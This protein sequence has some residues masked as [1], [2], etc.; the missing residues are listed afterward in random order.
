MELALPFGEKKLRFEAPW[1]PG[2]LAIGRR[3]ARPAPTPWDRLAHKA[4]DAPIGELPLEEIR[5]EDLQI[6]LLLE[7]DPHAPPAEEVLPVV[8]DR[9][10]QA[11]AEDDRIAIVGA[12]GLKPPAPEKMEEHLGGDIASRIRWSVHDPFSDRCAFRGFTALGTP[13]FVN[14]HVASAEFRLAVG[15]VEPHPTRGYSGGHDGILRACS[16]ETILHN[17]NLSFGPLSSYGHLGDNPCR[18]DADNVGRA[19]GLDYVLDFV[20]TPDGSPVGAFAGDPL[21]A[22]RAAA[23]Q[24]DRTVWGAEL[25]DLADAAIASPG[26]DR[27]T[28][29]PFEPRAIEFVAAGVKPGGSIAFLASP[30]MIPE[31]DDQWERSLLDLNIEE[32]IRLYE[33][34][35]WADPPPDVAR[36]LAAVVDAYLALRPFHYHRVLLV[37]SDLPAPALSRLG[38][39]QVETLDEAARIIAERHGRNARVALVPDAS[40]TLCLRQ[41]H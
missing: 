37:G 19:A 4:L 31:P 30:G 27:P 7:I 11:G 36:K 14:E 35:T 3:P 26:H 40:T 15:R 10:Y 8:L 12:C 29:T 34:R 21:K 33:R 28:E 13:V 20:V 24:G 41:T 16:A 22:Q 25:G 6:A 38:A 9:L 18:L 39:E 1:P 32:L 2:N 23:N 17:Q 5:L